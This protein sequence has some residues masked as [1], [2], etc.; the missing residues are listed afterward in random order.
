[1]QVQ[2]C[3]LFQIS[4]HIQKNHGQKSGTAYEFTISLGCCLRNQLPI[5][6]AK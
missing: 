3:K 1:M 4:A 2:E 5:E 6:T